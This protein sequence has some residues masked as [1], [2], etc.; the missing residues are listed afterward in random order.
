MT[1]QDI[2]DQLDLPAVDQI[3]F[4][5]PDLAAAMSHYAPL[6]GPWNTMETT[7]EQADYLGELQDCKLLIA[8]GKSGDLEIELIQPAGGH[9]PHQ[10]F[11]EA[12]GNGPHHLRYRTP[13]IDARIR[14]ARAIGYEPIWTKRWSPDIAFCYLQKPGATLV[15]EFLQMP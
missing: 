5:V 11:I 15:I 1:D 9:S 7:V 4:V 2:N 6:F 3:G 12:G 13:D 14:Q 8:F 10:D